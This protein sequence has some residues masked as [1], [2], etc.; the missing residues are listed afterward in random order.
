M[1][2]LFCAINNSLMKF[3]SVILTDVNIIRKLSWAVWRLLLLLKK[4][5]LTLF[6]A[7][8]R[9]TRE[10][11]FKSLP[12]T[13]NRSNNTDIDLFYIFTQTCLTTS[14][15]SLVLWSGETLIYP[16]SSR[17]KISY[18]YGDVAIIGEGL[19]TLALSRKFLGVFIVSCMLWHKARILRSDPKDRIM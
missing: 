4:K 3:Y 10:N 6:V 5:S 7:C 1:A 12:S 17:T 2:L 13:C 15:N 9:N 18:S 14:G 11:C 16:R 19:C 8:K